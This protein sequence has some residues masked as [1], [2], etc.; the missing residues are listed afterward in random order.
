MASFDMQNK[1]NFI[2]V[3]VLGGL[4]A[5]LAIGILLIRPAWSSLR[6][7]GRE[8]PEEQVKQQ[9][10]ELDRDR[11]KSA[12]EFFA[13]SGDDVKAVNT[14]VPTQGQVAQV[15]VVLERLAQTNG[16]VLTSFVPQQRPATSSVP[17]A[18]APTTNALEPVEITAQY[19][20]EYESLLSFF[21]NLERSQRV[22][23]VKSF[24]TATETNSRRLKGNITFT[25]YYQ[26]VEGINPTATPTPVPGGA[27]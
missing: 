25:V 13:K 2:A 9:Q 21:Y 6:E 1:Y 26:G 11:L 3:V 15:L 14:A 22:V 12:S 8:I 19:E 4:L 16:V 23:D 18:P 24:S 7:V 27:R 5:S 20:G 17:G 10:A